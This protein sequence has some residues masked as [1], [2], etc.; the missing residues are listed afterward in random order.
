MKK[1]FSLFLLP[2]FY[3]L[4]ASADLCNG[5]LLEAVENCGFPHAAGEVLHK[6]HSGKPNK[7]HEPKTFEQQHHRCP[8]PAKKITLLN[9]HIISR[10]TYPYYDLLL[11][12]TPDEKTPITYEKLYEILTHEAGF[13]LDKAG[14]LAR[15]YK[16]D[17]NDNCSLKVE[18][19]L[20][21]R[22]FGRTYPQRTWMAPPCPLMPS[23]A[24]LDQ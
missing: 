24:V 20:S 4:S 10:D 3:P 5:V 16:R 19:Y 17:P 15:R 12:D 7:N 8:W 13:S 6:L 21:A 14:D 9:C 11:N 1:Y 23:I 18:R 2:F 22:K